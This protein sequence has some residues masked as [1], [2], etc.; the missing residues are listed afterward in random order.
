K[1]FRQ[2]MRFGNIVAA[3]YPDLAGDPT[4]NATADPESAGTTYVDAALLARL[5]SWVDIPGSLQGP[6]LAY[7]VGDVYDCSLHQ[8]K[9]S[10]E[11]A[12][13]Y[14][15]STLFY[16]N[17]W[18]LFTARAIRTDRVSL[19]VAQ[20]LRELQTGWTGDSTTEGLPLRPLVRWG[21]KKLD[22][23]VSTNYRE[24]DG[25]AW[26]AL[27][28]DFAPQAQTLTLTLEEGLPPGEYLLEAGSAAVGC[29]VFPAGV[30]TSL[31]V[32]KRGPV[33]QVSFDIAPGLNLVRLTRT[34]AAPAPAGWDLAVDPPRLEADGLGGYTARVRVVN[35]GSSA[36]PAS[37]LEL[38]VAAVHPDGTLA[39]PPDLP[40]E[41]PLSQA[42]VN[43]GAVSGWKLPEVEKEFSIPPGSPV[44]ALLKQ[45]Y[46]L[47]L[48]AVISSTASEGDALNNEQSR[49]WFLAGIPTVP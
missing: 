19:N 46:G 34:G 49:C 44:G 24:L 41:V 47:Q 1:L 7:A 40:S 43:L 17:F 32:V 35:L 9:G 21:G 28:Q 27:V 12:G 5:K 37:N 39:S 33:A 29:D 16:R 15:K 48:R 25:S 3:V 2:G 6:A 42:P 13:L 8:G 38:D 36:A 11:L 45:G 18:P 30:S 23:A 4:L 14:Q 26:S 20:V 10:L 22:L 31:P